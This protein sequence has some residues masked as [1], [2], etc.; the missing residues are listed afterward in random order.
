MQ[1]VLIVH[2]SYGFWSHHECWSTESWTIAP[3]GSTRL[4]SCEPLVTM[5]WSTN[6]YTILFYI[7]FCFKTPFVTRAGDCLCWTHGQQHH[8]S[9]RNQAYLSITGIFSIRHITGFWHWGTLDS[10]SLLCLG[11]SEEAQSPKNPRKCGFSVALN[12]LR[13]GHLFK[14]KLKW[15]GNVASFDFSGKHMCQKTQIFGCS[16]Y[17]YERPRKHHEY[18]FGG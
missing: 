14:Y 10:S 2:G 9:C 8:N 17:V 15:E 5:C 1:L 16:L 6:Q 12:S 18:W 7:C 4:G 11:P 13:K 3:R